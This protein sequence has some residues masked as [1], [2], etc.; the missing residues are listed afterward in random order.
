[1]HILF[2]PGSRSYRHP[3]TP[4]SRRHPT[5]PR[6]LHAPPQQRPF[7]ATLMLAAL[8]LL[9][10]CVA[11]RP[12]QMMRR[13]TN[14]GCPAASSLAEYDLVLIAEGS[15]AARVVALCGMEALAVAA[16]FSLKVLWLTDAPVHAA[17]FSSLFSLP[18]H[19][20][21][22]KPDLRWAVED[23]SPECVAGPLLQSPPHGFRYKAASVGD[24]GAATGVGGSAA[25]GVFRMPVRLLVSTRASTWDG[26]AD[27]PCWM[28]DELAACLHSLH[29]SQAVA[30]L[31]AAEDIPRVRRS[32][33]AFLEDTSLDTCS[34]CPANISQIIPP[35]CEVC[36][37][38]RFTHSLAAC[39]ARRLAYDFLRDPSLDFTIAS[40]LPSA[41]AAAVGMFHV[42][43][44]PLLLEASRRRAQ[45]QCVGSGVRRRGEAGDEGM[46]GG[47]RRAECAELEVAEFLALSHAP[48]F[49]SSVPLSPEAELIT[50]LATALRWAAG[51]PFR[52]APVCTSP[53]LFPLASLRFAY[54]MIVDG[55]TR[56]WGKDG[57]GGGMGEEWGNGSSLHSF[58][59][60]T[61]LSSRLLPFVTPPPLSLSLPLP[62][63]LPISLALLLPLSL[64][65]PSSS[66]PV[67]P[68][69]LGLIYCFVE[70]VACTS[71]KMW[72]RAAHGFSNL[73]DY[74]YTHHA[75]LNGLTLMYRDLDED[76]AIRQLTR[77]DL[78]KFV[79]VRNPFSRLL[80][81]HADKLVN[82]GEKHNVTLWN[83]RVFGRERL[84]QHGE[85][86]D[87]P[88]GFKA[89]VR[90]VADIV[91]ET[92]GNG[93]AHIATQAQLCGLHMIR[94]DE[95][96][97]FET[98]HD[99]V[100]RVVTRLNRSQVDPA[101][102]FKLG[103]Q[104][105]KTRAE[106][107]MRAA[108]DKETIEIVRQAYAA[109]F[110]V[111]LNH[112]DYDIP[113]VLRDIAEGKGEGAHTGVEGKQLPEDG[114]QN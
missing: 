56:G 39:T 42:S 67:L 112:I 74:N 2:G 110:H 66:P 83:H 16:G 55:A 15:M 20:K 89:A 26:W 84:E 30:R 82:G 103:S 81:A 57:G 13:F 44:T 76:D 99:D 95:V 86:M 60:S 61:T 97:L 79:F 58:H 63:P 31:L 114:V 21:I 69:H 104:I 94:Y 4:R 59:P 28:A 50:G 29:P 1:M 49:F 9:V 78:V 100:R 18:A 7:A 62:L 34:G 107:R 90:M 96:G 70:K 71:W 35:F 25:S 80:S 6:V 88:V 5:T 52:Q 22:S 41:A 54:Q 77:K 75:H 48:A 23:T 53:K 38:R 45:L 98:L 19:P 106:Q 46:V 40:A 36:N 27:D 43:R 12:D 102:I 101:R 85:R 108:Y 32:T 91:R 51:P 111:P 113:D 65:S 64:P 47:G 33:A 73:T 14:R 93:D 105:H 109:D 37:T 3:S 24:C 11:L 17:P 87:V 68:E 72:L 8:A 92:G 10:A